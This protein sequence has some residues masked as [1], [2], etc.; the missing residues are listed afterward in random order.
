[1]HT[2]KRLFKDIHF[3]SCSLSIYSLFPIIPSLSLRPSFSLVVH[4]DLSS[5]PSC[6]TSLSLSPS[7]PPHFSFSQLPNVDALSMQTNPVCGCYFRNTL[8]LHELNLLI[9]VSQLTVS[10]LAP[11]AIP[12]YLS[13]LLNWP[14]AEFGS[15]GLEIFNTSMPGVASDLLHFELT[16]SSEDSLSL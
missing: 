1:M 3:H 11:A 12:S 7:P 6:F 9:H 13:I 16:H 10:I 14:K 8:D 4:L 15:T 2:C 5:K